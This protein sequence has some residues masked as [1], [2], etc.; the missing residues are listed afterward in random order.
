MRFVDNDTS[1][2][3]IPISNAKATKH[4]VQMGWNFQDHEVK[5]NVMDIKKALSFG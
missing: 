4:S 2:D 3:I 5:T 1:R